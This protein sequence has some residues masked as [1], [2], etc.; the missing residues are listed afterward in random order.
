MPA[1]AEG[2]WTQA[3][4]PKVLAEA[5]AWLAAGSLDLSGIG[6]VDSTGVALLLELTRR[7]NI[8]GTPLRFI[9]T[10][11]NL[12]TLANFFGVSELLKLQEHSI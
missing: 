8:A 2:E 11:A 12:L 7:A 6:N 5:K 4:A 1:R 10:P 9:N 3:S